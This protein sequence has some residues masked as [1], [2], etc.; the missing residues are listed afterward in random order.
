MEQK[1]ENAPETNSFPDY[2][3]IS[4]KNICKIGG[5]SVLII[6]ITYLIEIIGVIMGGWQPPTT[7]IGWFTLLQSNRIIGLFQLRILDNGC[8]GLYDSDVF[9]P[10]RN[11]QSGQSQ[12][13]GS[14]GSV[15]FHRDR[16][17]LQLR[18]KYFL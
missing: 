17:V 15:C 8:H 13:G 3:G 4:W 18:I 14:R 6:G 16:A 11:I 5:V 1:S 9:R 7:V 2:A 10:L 12:L